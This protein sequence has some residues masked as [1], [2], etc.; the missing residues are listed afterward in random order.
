MSRPLAGLRERDVKVETIPLD[1]LDPNSTIQLLAHDDCD[2]LLTGT[3]KC[4]RCDSFPLMN[5]YLRD[6]IVHE[7]CRMKRL[8]GTFVGRMGI[9]L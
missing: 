8:G 2:T 5:T 9:K 4:M 6:V 3:G 7:C 1:A